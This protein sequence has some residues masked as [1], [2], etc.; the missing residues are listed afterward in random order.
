MSPRDWQWFLDHGE[1][2][3]LWVA[4]V[5]PDLAEMLGAASNRVSLGHSYA[6]K[7]AEKHRL[8][9]AH[10]PMVFETI[11]YGYALADR[12]RHMTFLHFDRADWE[13]WFQVT[14]KRAMDDRALYV[15]TF[16]KTNAKEVQRKLRKYPVVRNKMGG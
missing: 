2:R 14:I 5:A 7:A 12:E 13:G 11:D 4:Q 16:Y 1:G 10:F 15:T 8:T 6:V 3:T 9:A